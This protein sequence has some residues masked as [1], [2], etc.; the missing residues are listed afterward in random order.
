VPAA[1]PAA[2]PGAGEPAKTAGDEKP[3][4]ATAEEKAA[5]KSKGSSGKSDKGRKK[6]GGESYA[7]RSGGEKRGG[8]TGGTGL[9][10]PTEGGAS[11]KGGK[12]P[13][14]GKTIDDMINEVGAKKTGGGGEEPPKPVVKL[15]TLT[16]SEI[17]TAMK[18]V[19]P[20]IQN[21]AN[22]FKQ[23]GTAMAQISVASGGR[24]TGATVTGK[25]KDTPTGACV[26]AA[27]KS[28]KFTPCQPMN[29]PWPFTLMPR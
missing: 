15:I 28:A 24:V 18:G 14:G 1:A 19:Q 21:C 10:L 8:D 22:Q 23:P 2:A 25:F 4:G 13:G 20:K 29:F 12:K 27:A 17:V 11:A 7:S 5:D 26:E 16:Q 9:P 6:T 3:A